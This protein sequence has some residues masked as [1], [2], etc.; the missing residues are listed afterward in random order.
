M[1]LVDGLPSFRPRPATAINLNEIVRHCQRELEVELLH[2]RQHWARQAADGLAQWVFN[3]LAL[4]LTDRVSAMAG[5]RLRVSATKF[6]CDGSAANPNIAD[7]R[8]TP[9]RTHAIGVPLVAPEA[10]FRAVPNAAMISPA[11]DWASVDDEVQ[12][13]MALKCWGRQFAQDPMHLV[14]K[15][16]RAGGRI[17]SA[18]ACFKQANRA[19]RTQT[20]T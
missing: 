7:R 18:T 6:V 5:M 2:A 10:A 16:L 4:L 8:Q 19:S 20:A 13:L 17:L 14:M 1:A 15:S 12:A 3:P 9:A 11:D